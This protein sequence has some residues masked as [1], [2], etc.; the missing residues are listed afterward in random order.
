MIIRSTAKNVPSTPKKIQLVA[1]AI[2]RLKPAEAIELL[3]AYNN[4]ASIS[5]AKTLKSAVANAVNNHNQ[6]VEDLAIHQILIGKGISFKRFLAGA[7]GRAKP[8]VKTRSHVTVELIVKQPKAPKAEAKV[9]KPK[10]E[11]SATPEVKKTTVKKVTKKES[12]K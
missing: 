9:E 10:V 2:K 4:K 3:T 6:K 12:N 1:E 7:R 5:V 8:Y 11:A